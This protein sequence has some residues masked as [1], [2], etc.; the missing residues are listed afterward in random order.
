[1]DEIENWTVPP[2]V[3]GPVPRK[4]RMAGPA[5]F[6]AVMAGILVAGSIPIL[7][8]LRGSNEEAKAF[9]EVLRAHGRE[10][11]GQI[12][13]VWSTGG[14]SPTRSVSYSF[15][16]DGSPVQGY[17][18]VPS[19]LFG[20]LQKVRSLPV[21]YLP[22]DPKT[23]HPAAWQEPVDAAWVAFP[24]PSLTM[25]VGLLLALYLRRFAAVMARGLPVPAVVTRC[26]SVKGGGLVGFQYRTRDGASFNGSS[27]F[28]RRKEVGAVLCVLYL[29]ENPGRSQVY[30]SV[31]FRAAE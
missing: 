15:T 2:E 1:M 16:A 22:S 19:E 30:P 25:A 24:L 4:T 21:Q 7:L 26:V 10:T 27:Q 6:M 18:S 3:S 28:P 5:I 14:K 8:A 12:I 17:S 29:P 9:N 23:N 20:G 13:R 11:T 31:L